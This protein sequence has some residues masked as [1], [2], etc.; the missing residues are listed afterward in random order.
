MRPADLPSIDKWPCGVRA[1]Y[2]SGCRCEACTIAN[3]VYANYRNQR[4]VYPQHRNGLVP[5]DK[6]RAHMKYLSKMGV[7][8]RAVAAAC[9]VSLTILEE[10]KMGRKATIRAQT[11]RKILAVTESSVS[12]GA[13]V[14]AVK[15]WRLIREMLREGCL[16]KGEISQRIGN[17]TPALQIKKGKVLA[18]TALKE[19]MA[20]V[21]LEKSLPDLCPNCSLEHTIEQRL[22]LVQRML[23]ATMHN[24]KSEWTC[25]YHGRRGERKLYRDL[26]TLKAI[27]YQGVWAL[28]S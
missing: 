11:E 5:A 1:K 27:Q 4:N 10:I 8:K 3:R 14:S 16:T 6:A 19:V 26:H 9:D 2:V 22:R 12:D 21:T 13:K 24:I 23:P 20:E 28:E 18:S 17:K 15:T 7:G 25:I